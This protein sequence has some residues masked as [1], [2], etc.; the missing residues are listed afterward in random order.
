MCSLASSL[1]YENRRV[2]QQTVLATVVGYVY[3]LLFFLGKG[4]LLPTIFLHAANNIA[5][6]CFHSTVRQR[7][8]TRDGS[9]REHRVGNSFNGKQ[10]NCDHISGATDNLHTNGTCTIAK[11]YSQWNPAGVLATTSPRPQ[12]SLRVDD[13]PETIP[14]NAHK[15]CRGPAEGGVIPRAGVGGTAST[16]T[17]MGYAGTVVAYL[18]AGRICHKYLRR[19]TTEASVCSGTGGVGGTVAASARPP[20]ANPSTRS[21]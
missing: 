2:Y 4:R 13:R 12:C 17:C 1:L 16:M 20:Y 8:D 11:G 7:H 14:Y 18:I 6:S 19:V 15:V 21:H 3:C 9:D 10:V 5:A